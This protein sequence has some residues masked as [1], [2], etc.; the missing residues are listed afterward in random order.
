MLTLWSITRQGNETVVAQKD[1]VWT[2]FV[3]TD[4]DHSVLVSAN[5]EL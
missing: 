3:L 4:M 2:E 5:A 1:Y